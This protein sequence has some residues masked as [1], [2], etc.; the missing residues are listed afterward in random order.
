MTGLA[1]FDGELIPKLRCSILK[2]AV[3]DFQR[4]PGWWTGK[5]DH[6]QRT[7]VVTQLNR[8]QVVEILRLVC[9]ENLICKK[10]FILDTFI[11]SEPMQRFKNRSDVRFWSSGDKIIEQTA[12]IQ[13]KSVTPANKSLHVD[14]VG[15]WSIPTLLSS[16]GFMYFC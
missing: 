11:Y 3:S 16:H 7:C 10:Q 13:I 15:S 8:Y 6:R 12:Q 5:S 2:R 14:T 1:K 9:C 4:G